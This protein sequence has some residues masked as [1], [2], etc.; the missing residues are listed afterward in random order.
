MHFTTQ[1]TQFGNAVYV[2]DL[3]VDLLDSEM[4]KIGYAVMPDDV[5]KTM[6]VRCERCYVH[7]DRNIGIATLNGNMLETVGHTAQMHLQQIV[8]N[9][10]FEIIWHV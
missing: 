3:N 4:I 7:H 9:Q 6:W 8:S 1:P 10:E 5:A 2:H